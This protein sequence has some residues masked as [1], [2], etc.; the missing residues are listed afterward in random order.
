MSGIGLCQTQFFFFLT[1][2]I[3]VQFNSVQ[4]LSCI[5]LFAT[6]RTAACQASLFITNSQS[7]FKFM[8]IKSVMPS[9]H[10][11]LCHPL[12][13]LSSTFPSIRVFFNESVLHI[14]WPKYYSFSF[15]IS[16]YSVRYRFDIYGLH[17]TEVSSL[18][19]Y[20]L[21]SFYHNWVLDFIKGFFCIY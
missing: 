4:S 1:F 16:P 9:N 18:Y 21:E 15:S 2:C 12:L 7:L 11:I 13:L 10:F 5:Q 20:F 19:A 17:C 14:R 3:G 8:F 6:P